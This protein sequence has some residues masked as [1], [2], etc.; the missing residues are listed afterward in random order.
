MIDALTYWWKRA[1]EAERKLAWL[2]KQKKEKP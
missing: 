1:I 2:A